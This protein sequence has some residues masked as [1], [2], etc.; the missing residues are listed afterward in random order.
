MAEKLQVHDFVEMDYTGKIANGAVFD[1]TDEKIAH[2][3]GL[4]HQH[5]AIQSA[6]ICIGEKQLLPGLDNELVGKEVGQEYTVVLPPEQAFGKRDVKHVRMIPLGTFKEHQVQP[7]PGLQVDVDGERGFVTRI[8]GGRVI[9]NFNHPLAGKEVTYT[10][11][12]RRK[13]TDLPEQIRSFL[14]SS[15]RIPTE[16]MNVVV[17]EGKV[18]V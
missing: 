17:D 8:A 13:V 11:K 6:V 12:V 2:Q 15:L 9:V 7:Q 1:T 14:H 3:A 16:Q 10:F 4:P 18:S 5:G